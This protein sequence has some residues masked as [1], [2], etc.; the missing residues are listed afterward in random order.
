MKLTI[1]YCAKSGIILSWTE[2]VLLVRRKF[3][4]VHRA[5][6]IKY[7]LLAKVIII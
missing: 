4:I 1:V 5:R 6:P 3:L 2:D 7:A